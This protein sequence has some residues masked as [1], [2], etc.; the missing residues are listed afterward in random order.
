MVIRL[1]KVSLWSQSFHESCNF[2]N[3]NAKGLN[4]VKWS[5][6]NEPNLLFLAQAQRLSWSTVDSSSFQLACWSILKIEKESKK[7][8]IRFSGLSHVFEQNL[9]SY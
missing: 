6:R 2:Y 1:F 5:F 7:E 3:V 9:I 8:D 4:N